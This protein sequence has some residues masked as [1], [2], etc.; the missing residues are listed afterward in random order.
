MHRITN[1]QILVQE[2]VSVRAQKHRYWFAW[3]LL[4]Q[5]LCFHKKESKIEL[6]FD[7]FYKGLLFFLA[8]SLKFVQFMMLIVVFLFLSHLSFL[9]SFFVARDPFMGDC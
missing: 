9:P 6:V 7:L 8:R 2:F 5:N 1:A 4:N 3:P